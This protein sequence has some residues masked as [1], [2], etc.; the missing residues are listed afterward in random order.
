MKFEIFQ[1]TQWEVKEEIVCKEYDKLMK[2]TQIVIYSDL[3]LTLLLYTMYR[4]KIVIC[5][6][7]RYITKNNKQW[8]KNESYLFSE[9]LQ[10]VRAIKNQL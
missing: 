10:R 5:L 2:N 7:E 6:F 1:K 3:T 4:Q 8:L 9:F